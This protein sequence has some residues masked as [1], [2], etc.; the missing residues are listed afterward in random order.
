MICLGV[1]IHPAKLNSAPLR[2]TAS[3]YTIESLKKE[4][5][6][7]TSKGVM[8]NGRLYNENAF[9]CAVRLVPLGT[10]LM[11]RNIANGRTV[12]VTATDK[13]GKRFAETRIDLSKAAFSQIAD[14]KRG[15]I[16]VEVEIVK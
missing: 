7:K 8:A 2:L 4:G 3:Y 11:V 16:P 6:W 13:I 9:T 1:L 15:L 5:T 14:L 10:R 12:F